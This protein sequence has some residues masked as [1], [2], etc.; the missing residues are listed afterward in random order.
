MCWELGQSPSA[1]TGLE[2][3][4]CGVY[5]P[6]EGR[7]ALAEGEGNALNPWEGGEEPLTDA[8]DDVLQKA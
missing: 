2:G 5:F 3:D 1:A 4:S 6:W 7:I 8:P